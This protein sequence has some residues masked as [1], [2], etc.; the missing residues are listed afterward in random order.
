MVKILK[1]LART[2]GISLEF[3]LLLL[4]GF[5]FGIRTSAFQTFL[6]QQAT[7][8]LSK[9]M[10]ANIRIGKV[11]IIFIDKVL[12]KDVYVEDKTGDTLAS[13]GTILATLDDYDLDKQEF[14][15]GNAL[16]ETGTISLFRDSI[17]GEYNYQF[18]VD[19]FDSGKKTTSSSEPPKI[20]VKSIDLKK[21]NFAYND[22]RK[23]YSDFGMD[24]DHLDFKN[25]YLSASNFSS[26]AGVIKTTI[27]HF[28]AKEKCGLWLSKLAATCTIN[29]DKG[30]FLNDLLIRTSRS[31][32]HASKL[33]LISKPMTGFNSFEDSVIFDAQLDSSLISMRDVSLFA[34]TLKG[35]NDKIYIQATVSRKIRNL[36]ISDLDLRFG[37]RSVVRGE[38]NLPDFRNLSKAK[39][40]EKL[41]YCL[42]D[43]QDLKK[44]R[45]PDNAGKHLS[46][47]SQVEQLAYI[48]LRETEFNGTLAQFSLKTNQIKTALG[49]VSIANG[50]N[51]NSL[52]AGGYAFTGNSGTK[53]DVVVDSFQ[54]G[55]FIN[56]D[57]LGGVK[58]AFDLTGV[59][60]Q[61]DG[62]RL[63]NF[64]GDLAYFGLNDYT[65]QNITVTEGSFKDN[66][67]KATTLIKDPHLDL[68]YSGEVDLNSMKFSN[69]SVDIPKADLGKLHLSD[70]PNAFLAVNISEVNLTGTDPETMSGSV[71]VNNIVFK[72][73]NET[74]SIPSLD[75][76]ITRGVQDEV[77][78][79]SE[80]FHAKLLGKFDTKTLPI[81]LNNLVAEI[82]PVYVP[83]QVF[84][85]GKTDNNV[86]VLDVTTGDLSHILGLYAPEIS[87]AENSILKMN[88]DG[89]N[90]TESVQ[91]NSSE[92]SYG[93]VGETNR[94]HLS[95]LS[96]NQNYTTSSDTII[97]T[98]SNGYISDSLQVDELN[99]QIGGLANKFTTHIDWNKQTANPSEFNF[100]TSFKEN[101]NIS[102]AIKPSN[103]SIK[104]KEWG[105]LNP[106]LIVYAK[107][108]FEITGLD[109]E[110]GDQK[111]ILDGLVSNSKTDELVLKTENIQLG[112]ISHLLGLGFNIDG[113]LNS[114]VR[115]KDLFEHPMVQGEIAANKLFFQG[116][117]VGDIH[118]DII[119]NNYKQALTVFGDLHYDL[120]AEGARN[121]EFEGNVYPL[122]EHDNLDL[123]LVFN[124]MDLQFANA[125]MDPAV[126][127]GIEG[128]IDGDIKVDGDFA[129]PK[130]NGNLKLND[131]KA[132]VGILGTTYT[133]NGPIQF[134]GDNGFII[135][136]LPI[137][138]QEGNYAYADASISHENF[139]NFNVSMDF[140]YDNLV[141]DFVNHAMGTYGR[142]YY[143]GKFMALDTRYKDGDI[144]YGRAYASGF[145][146]ISIDNAKTAITVDAKTEKGTKIDLAMFGSRTVG[147]YDFI[148]WAPLDTVKNK[149]IDL[150]GVEVR[151]NMDVTDDAELRL[152]F[153][154]KTGDVI[155][156]KGNCTK[157][158]DIFIGQ[159]NV[160]TM[161]G[162][163]V[164]SEGQYNLSMYGIKETFFIEKGSSVSWL[165]NPE[166]AD[167][168][169]TTFTNF[170][171]KITELSPQETTAQPVKCFLSV[172]QKL[173]K[174]EVT[175]DIEVP[176]LND[177]G[178]ALLA[179]IKND[180][181]VLASQFFYLLAFRTFKPLSGG[182]DLTGGA[183]GDLAGTYLTEG[184]GL[185][186]TEIK[187]GELTGFA[188]DKSFGE[189]GK[190]VLKTSVGVGNSNVDGTNQSSFIGDLV[191]QY[192]FNESETFKGFYSVQTNDKSAIS[193]ADKGVATQSVGVSYSEE[194]NN[195][196][197][198][199]VI[200]VIKNVFTGNKV[201]KNSTNQNEKPL[202]TNENKSVIVPQA[203][204]IPKKDN[205]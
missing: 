188:L 61:K 25:V 83:K 48:D 15:L 22:Y 40:K 81:A 3:V 184:L 12:L 35:M 203:T 119:W 171:A 58:G 73:N 14:V 27:T 11:E 152:I 166:E 80:V 137:R 70:D 190:L 150:T 16:I 159:D 202:P 45:L 53:F 180:E 75:L 6:G 36:C 24:F 8:F 107:D 103:F 186:N 111:L 2:V 77:I 124:R 72:E 39:F 26:N 29:P 183:I 94:Y 46:L 144:Y 191:L 1:I 165:G 57:L 74:V 153:N 49:R 194:F 114:N 19:Y 109:I 176:N 51:F 56:N 44:F 177:N 126:V 170:K 196:K 108:H 87:V 95:N 157:P 143:T 92:I 158:F 9:D 82:I 28:S 132:N 138:D 178:K 198:S 59:F 136:Q 55:K 60:G 4:I 97:L 200:E 121:F 88:Y 13:I 102:L 98:A 169:I 67:V 17:K 148:D 146:N 31:T 122:K 86:F 30:L 113:I 52:A 175:L 112:E 193:N 149:P 89:I 110:R 162:D 151:L 47:P 123:S 161:E 5:A 50:M 90:K 69:V 131:G 41:D 42:L 160:V 100:N 105:I 195:A 68:A 167:L 84:P 133:A 163:Y 93:K 78:L 76:S 32:I 199:R 20:T 104:E 181:E 205:E 156:A 130:I 155:T 65:Y 172:G 187:V 201:I 101:Q 134:D 10:D 34:P 85:K 64:N 182:N 192:L 168:D 33:N 96:L 147:D 127:G 173:S 140:Y 128:K 79:E 54:L 71:K 174:P 116:I 37:T 43:V 23:S 63:E 204:E 154:E 106:A 145:A 38:I 117:K 118:S 120:A 62:F 18:L 115:L 135:A 91:F 189:K 139:T 185:K 141:D 179:S 142:K 197:D 21:I 99:I 125:F 129:E 66:I 7:A 164:I